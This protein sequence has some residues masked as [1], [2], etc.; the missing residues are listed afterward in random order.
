M[1]TI[2]VTKSVMD[3]VVGFEKRRSF[4]WLGRF[5]FILF[6][7]GALGIWVFWIAAAEIFE[8]QTLEL[9][10][11]F[12]QDREIIAQFWQDTMMVFWEELPQ[13]KLA[14]SFIALLGAI[15]LVIFTRKKFMIV[16]RKI[17]Q[18]AKYGRNTENTK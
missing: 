13:R 2:D 16:W 15:L 14:V 9:L 1:K 11:L 5:F 3:Q 6:V 17:Q 7:L 4:G 12:T 18:L 10:T 8:R